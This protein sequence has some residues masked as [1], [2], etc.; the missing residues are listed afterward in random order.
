MGCSSAWWSTAF[1]R[2]GPEVRILS[3]RSVKPMIETLARKYIILLECQVIDIP[4]HSE[5][6][7]ELV[8]YKALY[9]CK[10][11]G[12]NRLSGRPISTFLAAAQGHHGNGKPIDD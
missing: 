2:Q 4:L 12:N 10:E 8:V 5:T 6:H 3:P 11:F 7:Q 1:G 9:N